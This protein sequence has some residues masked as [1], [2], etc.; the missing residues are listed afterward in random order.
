[1]EAYTQLPVSPLISFVT[2]ELTARRNKKDTGRRRGRPLARLP[3]QLLRYPGH[4]A[5]LEAR[6]GE[7][8]FTWHSLAPAAGYGRCAIGRTARHFIYS[9][10][11]LE[12]V[13]QPDDYHSVVQQGRVET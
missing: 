7:L 4:V 1:M 5:S 2:S 6:S 11:P 12:G 10:E 8:V 13:W 3:G 9:G